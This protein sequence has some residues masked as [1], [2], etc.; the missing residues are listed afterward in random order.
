MKNYKTQL[1]N[2]AANAKVKS[3]WSRGV[4]D[5]SLE[6]LEDL[7]Y[8]S[9][10]DIKDYNTFRAILLNGASSWHAY[11]WGGCSLIYDEDIARRLCTPSELNRKDYGR[12]SPNS[13][14]EWLD[15]QERAIHQSFC[16]LNA[17]RQRI[18][19]EC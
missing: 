1:E 11:S 9:Y 16:R 14:E 3:A 15:V 18:L 19:Q 17:Y 10:E 13:R 6:L 5:Y 8:L 2:I 7:D 4:K 12:L